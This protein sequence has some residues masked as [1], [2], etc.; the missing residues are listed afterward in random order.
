[1]SD[2]GIAWRS[3]QKTIRIDAAQ[4]FVDRQPNVDLSGR[5]LYKHRNRGRGAQ[6]RWME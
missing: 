1:M 5:S 6:E 2:K 3:G 4:G